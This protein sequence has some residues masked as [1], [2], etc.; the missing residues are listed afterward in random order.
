MWY[1]LRLD[2]IQGCWLLLLWKCLLLLLWECLLLLWFLLLLLR[3]GDRRR[4][5]PG[6]RCESRVQL[7]SQRFAASYA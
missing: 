3:W 4:L 1:H 7:W 5:L 2:H 6:S